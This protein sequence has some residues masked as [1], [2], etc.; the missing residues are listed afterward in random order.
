MKYCFTTLAV[1]E[2]YE[3]KTKELYENLRDRTTNCDF[4]ITTNNAEYP[5]MGERIHVNVMKPTPLHDSRGGFSFHL[6][7]KC[8]SLKHVVEYQKQMLITNPDF[9]K[10]DYI[11]FT[12]GDW[13]MH[14]EF[15]EEKILSL[16]NFMNDDDLDLIFERPARIGDG[17]INPEQTFYRDKIYDY[18]ILEHTKWD[19]AHVVNEQFLVFKN[20]YKFRFFVQ[21]W[22]QFLWYSIENDIRNYPDGFE[23]GISALEADMKWS[24]NGWFHL[25]RNCFGFFTKSNDYHVRF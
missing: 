19:E 13:I 9:K 6:N 24:Y 15:S 20:N 5:E 18:D 16:F 11:I 1:G 23:I 22:E 10:Y 12:D 17:K 2:P 8:L 21:R 14:E 25:V 7:Y 3:T 4:F